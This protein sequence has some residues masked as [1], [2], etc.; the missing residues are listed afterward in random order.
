MNL[1]TK[2]AESLGGRLL[3]FSY[4]VADDPLGR[5]DNRRDP[6]PACGRL[7]EYCP[8]DLCNQFHDACLGHIEGATSACCGHG[9]GVGHIIIG[10]ALNT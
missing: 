9:V 3:A 1:V 5:L 8:R 6:C 2:L 10:D 7:G 4:D